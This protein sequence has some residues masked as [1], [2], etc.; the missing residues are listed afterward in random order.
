MMPGKQH[1]LLSPLLALW[2]AGTLSGQTN[3]GPETRADPG[4]APETNGQTTA[5]PPPAAVDP[6]VEILSQ[7]TDPFQFRFRG[8]DGAAIGEGMI[9]VDSRS[10][11]ASIRVRALVRMDNQK[12]AALLQLRSGEPAVL[13]REG[14]LLY[15]PPDPA[16]RPRPGGTGADDAL[17]LLVDSIQDDFVMVAPKKN[18]EA[19]MMLR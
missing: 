12:P 8:A 15:V 17:Y 16:T 9:P 2:L 4:F 6:I 11:S 1:L 3:A 18:P 10:V 19:V 14:D 13:V 5:I 7:G